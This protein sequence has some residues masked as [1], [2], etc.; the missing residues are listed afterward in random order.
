MNETPDD[1]VC[2]YASDDLNHRK[3]PAPFGGPRTPR[4]ATCQRS[5]KRA[6]RLKA[7]AT[8][9]VRI[10]KVTPD[11]AAAILEVQGGRCPICLRATGASKALAIEHDH[12]HCGVCYGPQS[13]GAIESIRG[14]V[15]GPCNSMLAHARDDAQMFMRA[16]RYLLDPPGPKVLHRM[17]N[18][19]PPASV[20]S[21]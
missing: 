3:R 21:P 13:C 7:R 6:A 2:M 18:Q 20:Q 11:E 5:W 9:I 1:L 16:A 12:S 19:E 4:C 8:R 10:Y 17:R 14:R 15:C